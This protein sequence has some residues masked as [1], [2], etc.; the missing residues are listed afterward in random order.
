MKQRGS[1]VSTKSEQTKRMQ[2]HLWEKCYWFPKTVGSNQGCGA[3]ARRRSQKFEWWSRSLKFEFPF[4]RHILYSKPVVKIMRRFLIFNGPKRSGAAG[5]KN[6]EVWASVKNFKC[7]ELVPQPEI[8]VSAPQSWFELLRTL[9]LG[10]YL[11][12]KFFKAVGKLVSLSY[13]AF[14]PVLFMSRRL[15]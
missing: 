15:Q 11:Q 4:N 6:F 3:G 12:V 9:P 13:M 1:L 10:F 14:P 2:L 7:L 5:A 8:W